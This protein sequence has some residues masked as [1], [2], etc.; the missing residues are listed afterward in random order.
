MTKPLYILNASAGSGKTYNL[1][2]HYLKLL[3]VPENP[4][5]LSQILAMTFTNKASVEMKTRIIRDL[6]H[7]S[8][9]HLEDQK[10]QEFSMFCASK[11]ED[12]R[13]QARIVLRKLLHRY[14][15]FQ[16]Q[17][18]DKFNLR[19]IRAFS[20][21]LNL[22]DQ[23][24]VVFDETYLLEQ[25][26][27]DLLNNIQIKEESTIKENAINYALSSLGEDNKW[28]I[29]TS[30]LKIGSLL[31]DERNFD[32]IKSLVT[33][34]LDKNNFNSWKKYQL[35]LNENITN[36]IQTFKTKFE[37]SNLSESDLKGK[38]TS[39]KGILKLVQLPKKLNHGKIQENFSSIKSAT[40][41]M[42]S[43]EHKLP[44]L[45]ISFLELKNWWENN[46]MN[47]FLNELKI[48]Q[49][50]ILSILKELAKYMEKLRKESS[51]IRISE[52][53]KLIDELVEGEEAPYIYERLGTRFKHYFLDEFQDTSLLQW[54]NLI[55]LVY[56][57]I[58]NGHFS[59]IVGDPK[60]SIY[61]FKNGVAEQFISLPKLYNPTNK[62]RLDRISSYFE[63]QGKVENLPDNWRS[64]TKI[65]DFNNRFF[66]RL[67]SKM[68]ESGKDYYRSIQQN[69][70][71]KE[72]G[73][74]TYELLDK[75]QVDDE[76]PKKIISYV[77]K[78]LDDGYN[79]GDICILGRKK[80]E[81]L[82]Y[83][84]ILKS[85]GFDVVSA[86]SLLI[87]ADYYVRLI[88]WACKWV[89]QP[90]SIQH[91]K[92]F[93]AFYFNLNTTELSHENYLKCF[94][95]IEGKSIFS[96]KLLEQFT[97]IS[98]EE[99]SRNYTSVHELILKICRVLKLNEID[100][101]YLQQ[102]LDYA[103]QFDQR[104]GPDLG[105]FLT[106]YFQSGN[107]ISVQLP[108]NQFSIKI[109]TAHKSKGLE[110][111]VVIIPNID[112]SSDKTKEKVDL[113][114]IDQS[115]IQFKY[116][117]IFKS[118]PI[119]NE[120]IEKEEEAVLMDT[121]NLLYVALTRAVDRLHLI[122]I[123]GNK[124]SD[125]ITTIL[126]EEFEEL[127]ELPLVYGEFV[128]HQEHAA[129]IEDSKFQPKDI[130]QFIWFPTISLQSPLE[131]EDFG[132]QQQQQF[133]IYFHSILEQ[134][135]S[136]E[137]CIKNLERLILKGKIPIEYTSRLTEEVHYLFQQ[138]EYPELLKSG[139]PNFEQTLIVDKITKL[140]P[141]VF[142]VSDSKIIVVDFKTG[143]FREKFKQQMQSYVIALEHIYN[144][145]VSAKIYLVEERKFI[146]LEQKLL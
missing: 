17:T 19:L 24:E 76:L 32:T 74:V 139:K 128:Q 49:F 92:L 124:K 81:C 123:S 36:K 135:T 83:A 42:E 86:D 52:F 110:F 64:K 15:D 131:K 99:L 103:F 143:T 79:P 65:V 41:G 117:N 146:E 84:N 137:T 91:A 9:T 102:L 43:I 101:P 130:S 27:D 142:I 115:F 1:V 33:N 13:K 80:N 34:E 63:S 2:R 58:S 35:E 26:I 31:K 109:M 7:L 104:I 118:M 112:F 50:Y 67:K 94:E 69:P 93:A 23:F 59:F 113:T 25:S 114:Q 5:E 75:E 134:G 39:Y 88:I 28:D 133:G 56:E 129:K 14:E 120:M 72:G 77:T 132:L 30:L 45:Y 87:H 51:I 140:R 119:F 73:I 12:V 70:R 21:D 60:Q 40:T 90:N 145:D 138:S 6:H 54:Q 10:L 127:G 96:L 107:K 89:N 136:L 82:Q 71:G 18:I 53:N 111:P 11:P 144:L 38:S 125:V 20:R 105:M 47:Y 106:D 95:Q 121:Y 141:D 57:G 61:R 29:K 22:P 4:S 48:Q 85:K 126:K 62:L 46:Q 16:V 78:A 122:H 97:G 66:T 55:P 3:L 108:E 37:R 68:P 44:D 8:K 98:S 100:N 116:T